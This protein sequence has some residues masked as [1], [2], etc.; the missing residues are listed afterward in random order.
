MSVNNTVGMSR[1]ACVVEAESPRGA[2]TARAKGNESSHKGG[3]SK[4]GFSNLCVIIAIIT[5]ITIITIIIIIIIIIIIVIIII[6]MF[7]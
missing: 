5:I 7:V 4:G 6:I 3:F 2:R 1:C